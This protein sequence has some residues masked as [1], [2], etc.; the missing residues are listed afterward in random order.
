MLLF[1]YVTPSAY[2]VHRNVLRSPEDVRLV[3]DYT[4]SLEDPVSQATSQGEYG[5]DD[6]A[7]ILG[8]IALLAA[9][10]AHTENLSALLVGDLMQSLIGWAST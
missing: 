10:N 1:G 5:C 3:R 4:S 9:K 6:E 7:V 8:D 2:M